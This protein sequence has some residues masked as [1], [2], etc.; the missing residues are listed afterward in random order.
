MVALERMK[1]K[2]LELMGDLKEVAV[3]EPLRT[4]SPESPQ[5]KNRSISRPRDDRSQSS[6]R[7]GAQEILGNS[8][9]NLP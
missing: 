1:A 6:L 2:Q 7:R 9:N 3:G 4:H 8:I 5:P